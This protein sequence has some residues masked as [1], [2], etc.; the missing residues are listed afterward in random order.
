MKLVQLPKEP[1]VIYLMAETEEDRIVLEALRICGRNAVE[2]GRVYEDDVSQDLVDGPAMFTAVMD[3][4]SGDPEAKNCRNCHVDRETH[5]VKICEE[6]R[7]KWQTE[8]MRNLARIELKVPC[9]CAGLEP[10]MPSFDARTGHGKDCLVPIL[11][12]TQRQVPS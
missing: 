1:R 4:L 5:Q 8:Y 2:A 11:E 10:Y 9:T 7:Q 12:R 6:H 3:Y